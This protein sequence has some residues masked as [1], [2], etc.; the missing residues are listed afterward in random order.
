MSF[1]WFLLK[2]LLEN[3]YVYGW[4]GVAIFF[5]V[6]TVHVHANANWIRVAWRACVSSI[7]VV[8][9]FHLVF[10]DASVLAE[11]FPQ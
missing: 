10:L 9:R 7:D 4:R 3:F 5:C 11:R 6:S 8:G 1:A 2:D